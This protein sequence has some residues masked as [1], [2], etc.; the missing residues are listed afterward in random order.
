MKKLL[1]VLMVSILVF[2]AT[3]CGD[4]KAP[5]SSDGGSAQNGDAT[6]IT[7]AASPTPHAEIL[8]AL[9]DKLADEGIE[10]KVKV[11]N[12][13]VVPNT[14]VED[15]EVDA[16]YFQHLDYLE[17]FNEKNGTH[18]VSAAGIH[19]EPMGIF[20]GKDKSATL[21][22]IADGAKIAIP[23]DTTNEA[24]ALQLLV[25]EGLI[26]LD[27]EAGLEATPKDVTKNEHKIEFVEME[28]AALPTVLADVDFAV[29]N[30]NYALGAGLTE[31][32]GLAFE[33]ADSEAAKTYTNALVVKEGN[34]DNPAIKK[35]V[36]A[37]TSDE[38]RAFLEEKYKGMLIPV[39]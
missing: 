15:G 16:N 8:E 1:A 30:G 18:L 6:T 39:F 7:V 28:A 12:D 17:D 29:I 9:K 27:P 35:L 10:L 37:L 22:K 34:E 13:Y 4:Q 11:Y 3:A 24:R 5:A 19:Y 33:A 21:D 38:C 32:D 23:N 25:A 14:V 26:E 31:A 2:A 20:P 36:E